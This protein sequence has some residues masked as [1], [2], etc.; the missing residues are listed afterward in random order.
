MKTRFSVL[1]TL[2]CLLL[3]WFVSC[4]K[5]DDP[6]VIPGST[7]GPGSNTST[8][9][10]KSS[11][12]TITAFT[13]AALSPAV[14]ATI[15]ATAKT[16]SA[17]VALGTDVTKLVPTITIAD[18]A[19]VSPASGVAQDFSRA[20]TYTVTAEDGSTQAYTTTVT[21]DK[22]VVNTS[23]QILFAASPNSSKPTFASYD[24]VTGNK[25]IDYADQNQIVSGISMPVV[26]NGILYTTRASGTPGSSSADMRAVEIKTGTVKWQYNKDVKDIPLG[27]PILSNGL[28]YFQDGGKQYGGNEKLIALDA[29]TG[30]KKWEYQESGATT[31][32]AMT[33]MNGIVYFNAD[34][35]SRLVALDNTGKKIWSKDGFNTVS[36]TVVGNII[37]VSNYD[38]LYALDAATGTQKWKVANLSDDQY[39]LS[40]V[41]TVG[42]GLLYIG[43]KKM[44]AFDAATGIKKW[45]FS[46]ELGVS[47]SP[48]L[49]DGIVYFGDDG[50]T[51]HGGK[52]YALDAKTGAR[53]WDFAFNNPV[54]A[55]SGYAISAPIAANGIV[56]IASKNGLYQL[57]AIAG[58]QKSL[59]ANLGSPEVIAIK[60][61]VYYPTSSGMQQ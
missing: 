35:Q 41:C 57:D 25:L 37:Y 60:D 22:P 29:N 10:T 42:D 6:V 30:E 59:F 24:L 61:K 39:A 20:V 7:T 51:K 1:S 36:I 4:K 15:D 13:L 44:Y 48:Y 14:N 27:V 43:G 32:R 23:D 38:A 11:A 5:T 2:F 50:M 53:K 52:F 31:I 28:L 40:R 45:E 56:Y 21:V 3:L 33:A 26:Y 9:G 34:K 54:S 19:T 49:T 17:T 46:P 18:K 58:T 8:T 12:K 16:I 55:S 47:T